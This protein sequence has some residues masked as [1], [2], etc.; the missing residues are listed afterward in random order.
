VCVQACQL[1]LIQMVIASYFLVVHTDFGLLVSTVLRVT[2]SAATQCVDVTHIS[3][4]CGYLLCSGN[5]ESD[6]FDGRNVLQ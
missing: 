3:L 2:L 4:R 1:C 5:F 6:P